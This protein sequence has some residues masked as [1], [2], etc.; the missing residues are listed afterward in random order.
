[1]DWVELR[2]LVRDG[3]GLPIAAGSS[4]EDED[5]SPGETGQ[6]QE[7]TYLK[8][9]LDDDAT[10][11]GSL[12]VCRVDRVVLGQMPLPA[13]GTARGVATLTEAAGV[14][15]DGWSVVVGKPDSD[16]DVRVNVMALLRNDG[17]STLPRVVF[18]VRFIKRKGDEESSDDVD[19]LGL[20]PGERRVAEAYT[21]LKE[22]WLS[23]GM[24]AEVSLRVFTDL[25]AATFEPQ[26][27]ELRAR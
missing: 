4:E 24:T 22:R 3:A 16:G 2:Y 13:A 5:L 17:A 18:Q 21:F 27:L 10:V 9:G 20:A 1:V 7:S 25:G 8:I 6:I 11:S 14:A 23:K 12:R 26:G 19:V 15:V